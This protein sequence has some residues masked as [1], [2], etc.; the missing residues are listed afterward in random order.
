MSHLQEKIMG[1]ARENSTS[2][3][4]VYTLP[5]RTTAIIKSI[6]VCNTS[7]SDTTFRVFIDDDGSTYDQSTALFYDVDLPA[8]ETLTFDSFTAMSTVNGTIGYSSGLANAV[9][10]T[11]FGAEIS[12]A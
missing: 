8:D 7:G 1:Q 6:V 4:T 10:V 12:T 9:T 5:S 11:I 2:A 3:V